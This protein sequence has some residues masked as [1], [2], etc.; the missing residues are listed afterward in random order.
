[1]GTLGTEKQFIIQR[2]PLF[3]VYLIYIAIYPFP[4]RQSANTVSTVLGKLVVRFTTV[5]GELVVRVS[6]VL[7]ELVVRF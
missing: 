5:L 2:C 6:T 1:M 4:Q 3:S 7:G